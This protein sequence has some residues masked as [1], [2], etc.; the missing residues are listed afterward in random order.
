MNCCLGR[1]N[2]RTECIQSVTQV[3]PKSGSQYHLSKLQKNGLPRT[4]AMMKI[5]LYGIT[6]V[7]KLIYQR[8]IFAASCEQ[9]PLM[10]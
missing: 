9:V 7:F 2:C 10:D 1:L 3:M 4:L 8:V 6:L 5:T